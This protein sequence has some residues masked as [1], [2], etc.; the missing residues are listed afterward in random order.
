MTAARVKVYDLFPCGRGLS[1]MTAD[2]HGETITVAAGSIRQA[3]YLAGRMVWSGGP[4]QLVGVVERYTRGGPDEGWYQLW[5]GCRI[6]GG[7]CLK[8]GAGQR[9]IVAAMR[10]HLDRCHVEDRDAS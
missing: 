8:H 3:Y 9:A 10:R 4:G 6:H 2:Y 7:L 1:A 5:C